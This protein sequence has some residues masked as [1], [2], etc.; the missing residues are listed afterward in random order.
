M[1]FE[2]DIKYII[3]GASSYVLTCMEKVP[4]SSATMSV[5]EIKY[6]SFQLKCSVTL[7]IEAPMLRILTKP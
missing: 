4:L 1:F 3:N 7:Y 5:L 6:H 2:Q